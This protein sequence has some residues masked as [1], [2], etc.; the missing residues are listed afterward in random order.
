MA[1]KSQQNAQEAM[2]I[3][4]E[5]AVFEIMRYGGV[6]RYFTEL[7]NRLPTAAQPHVLG[8]TDRPGGLTNERLAYHEVKT[9]P[10][11]KL[12]RKAWRPLQHARL[13]KSID[14]NPANVV[15][16]TY[17]SGLC[18]RKIQKSRQPM[19]ITVYDFIHEAYPESDPGGKHR[20][21]KARAIEMADRIC[22]ISQFTYD[23]LCSRYP[24]A[25]QRASVTR[26]R[27]RAFRHRPC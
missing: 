18:K 9:Q 15:H 21:Q 13:T 26:L 19:V 11:V 1:L 14:A 25:A 10:P 22:C 6:A 16:W 12:F 27:Y 2:K 20:A 5:G 23:E 3:L 24:S 17:Y 4:Y 7:I 8:P